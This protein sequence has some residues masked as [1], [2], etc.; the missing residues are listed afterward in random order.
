MPTKLPIGKILL[1]Q[2]KQLDQGLAGALVIMFTAT[3]K[4][5]TI[6]SSL[7]NTGHPPYKR[8]YK[9]L[10][11]QLQGAN[12]LVVGEVCQ[13]ESYKSS[14][15]E[16]LQTARAV[17]SCQPTRLFLHGF[18]IYNGMI[19]LYL[20][21]RSRVYA[22]KY[23]NSAQSPDRFLT[24]LGGYMCMNDE[25]WGISSLVRD[26][27][28]GKYILCE[29]DKYK[30]GVMHL[31]LDDPPIFERV[32]RNIIS[33]G[34][35]CY[36]ARRSTSENWEFAVKL[37]WVKVG[38]KS[39]AETLK[40]INEENVAGVLQLI[41]HQAIYSTASLYKSLLADAQLRR[42][43]YDTLLSGPSNTGFS[44]D[45]DV[46]ESVVMDAQSGQSNGDRTLNC[47][48][49]SP[50]G[51]S[52]HK[53]KT[54]SMLLHALRDAVKAHRSLYQG[55]KILH[56]DLNPS[57]II[58]PSSVFKNEQTDVRGVLIDF[59]NAKKQFEGVGTPPFEAIG[60]LQAYLPNNSHTYRHD[61]ESIFYSFLFLAICPGPVPSGE[62]Q[63]QLPPKSAL[64]YWKQGRPI[65][66]VRRKMHDMDA[67]N[68]PR[69][70]AEFTPRF[71]KLKGL[72]EELRGVLFP[73][74][75]GKLWT[76][77][78]MT[79]E[80]TNALYDSMFGSFDMAIKETPTL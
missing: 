25:E 4:A 1:P 57:N 78:D 7:A 9:L 16:L 50:V 68:F 38:Q 76:G 23:F 6:S 36:R 42:L 27:G 44:V 48:V 58:I 41:Q 34:L 69:I 45:P 61:L 46:K 19:Q 65:D 70:V 52:L 12:V 71:E 80:G 75:D 29:D 35:T 24:V 63:L 77:T 64:E 13:D 47:T 20:F 15:Q 28:Q 79:D 37:K 74:R 11:I 18:H 39:E 49:V 22:C 56:Q 31:V 14:V 53:F 5:S 2:E 17:F 59:D 3:K 72:A 21:D 43:R 32:N 30:S 40:M 54:V 73:M 10:N 51:E 33:D 55:G 62:N 60:V 26:D 8:L 66:I 67:D